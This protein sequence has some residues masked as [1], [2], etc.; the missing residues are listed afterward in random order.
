MLYVVH[1][2]FHWSESTVEG[3]QRGHG[4]V[5]MV[6]HADEVDDAVDNQAALSEETAIR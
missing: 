5:A 6:Q 1:L 2:S 4:H 3:P